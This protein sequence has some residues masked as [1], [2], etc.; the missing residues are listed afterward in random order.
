[1]TPAERL[2]IDVEDVPFQAIDFERR[3]PAGEPPELIFTT[4]V[5][6]LVLV[7]RDHPLWMSGGEAA[8]P[9][10]RVRPGLDARITRAAYYRLLEHVELKQQR[11]YVQSAGIEFL[12]GQAA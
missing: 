4:N 12:L 10:L 9:Y 6:D 11:A 3:A 1:M 7:D 2:L 8:R 5:G